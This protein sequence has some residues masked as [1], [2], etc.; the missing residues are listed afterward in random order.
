MVGFS[1]SLLLPQQ[2]AAQLRHA[3]PQP[4]AATRCQLRTQCGARCGSEPEQAR[5]FSDCSRCK[6]HLRL[7]FDGANCNVHD[8]FAC[9]TRKSR[10][11]LFDPLRIVVSNRQI[12]RRTNVACVT[13]H[14]PAA[15]R[16]DSVGIILSHASDRSASALHAVMLPH[17]RPCCSGRCAAGNVSSAHQ[18]MRCRQTAS[19]PFGTSAQRAARLTPPHSVAPTDVQQGRSGALRA[20]KEISTELRMKRLASG[21]LQA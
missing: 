10:A 14:A 1:R 4:T 13:L 18:L 11:T 17:H 6:T 19:R 5:W 9:C 2:A 3:P 7:S 16:L 20:W 15:W 12:M 8:L 21:G